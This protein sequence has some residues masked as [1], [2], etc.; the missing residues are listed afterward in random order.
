MHDGSEVVGKTQIE[1]VHEFV[2]VAEVLWRNVSEQ[3]KTIHS[4]DRYS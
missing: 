1:A 2:G 4:R 3:L